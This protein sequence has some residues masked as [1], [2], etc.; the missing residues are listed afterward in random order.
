MKV[1]Y[2]HQYFVTPRGPGGIRSYEMAKRMVLRGISVTMVCGS[3]VGS[4]T[5]LTAP[6]VR[7]RRR[8]NVDGI[9]VI[10]FD[11]SYQN[12]DSFI[13][14]TITF[15]KFAFRGVL[16]ALS[17]EYDVLFATSTPLTAGVPGIFARWLRKKDFVF[18]VRD[19]WPELPKAMG[20]IKNPLVLWSMSFL[21][22]VT[23][24]SAN[25]L[26][27]LAPGIVDGIAK[28]NI[29]RDRIIFIPNGC[30]L[31]IF[32]E[33]VE[34]WRPN[35]ITDS[36]LLA[37]FTGAHG[38]AN[39]LESLL[40]VAIELKK[41]KRDDIKI[42]LIGQG[43]LKKQLY[44]KAVSLDLSNVLFMDPVPKTKLASLL[45]GAD[46]GLQI[47][48]NVPAFYNG[49]SPNK[50]FD[51]LASGLPVL[52]NYPGWLAELVRSNG[53]GYVVPPDDSVAFANILEQIADNK[54]ILRIK[55]EN[56]LILAHS[57]FARKILADSLVDWIEKTFE[58]K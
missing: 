37:V 31:D 41:R 36:D 55:R 28:K 18:E 47:L 12:K 6:F 14:R 52:I 15:L 38:I 23:Y 21:E 39:G 2:F 20:V 32:S 35:G 19:L 17:E 16:L 49:T 24:K 13:K 42:L 22:W 27:G 50:F 53:C 8:G 57:K 45:A 44:S 51:Y 1:L 58:S 29:S 48:A 46:I 5:G 3:V 25:R 26:V 33:N 34:P 43:K 9:D 10:E 7:G 54:N 4:E 56:S 11:L 40:D 30:D